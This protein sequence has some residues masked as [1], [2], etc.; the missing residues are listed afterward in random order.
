MEQYAGAVLAVIAD[1]VAIAGWRCGKIRREGSVAPSDAAVLFVGEYYAIVEGEVR[2]VPIYTSPKTENDYELSDRIAVDGFSF[3]AK[4]NHVFWNYTYKKENSFKTEVREKLEAL[5]KE[6]NVE[7]EDDVA[8]MER[9][10]SSM[11]DYWTMHGCM[12]LEF[13][14]KEKCLYATKQ[15]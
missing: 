13:Y 10:L 4:F 9:R 6:N 14:T 2:K 8:R 1:D 11:K 12:A 7:N 5:K 15:S 3:D